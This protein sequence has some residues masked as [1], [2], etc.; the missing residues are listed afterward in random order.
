M[1]N[2]IYLQLGYGG[3]V[4]SNDTAF[5]DRFM[6]WEGIYELIEK[7]GGF[8]N[9]ELMLLQNEW[10]ESSYINLKNTT[11]VNDIDKHVIKLTNDDI[12]DGYDF[13][14]GNDYHIIATL[15]P[16]S[17]HTKNTHQKIN[18]KSNPISN[19]ILNL[20]NEKPFV[21]LHIRKGSGV[22]GSKYSQTNTEGY[23]DFTWDY[24]DKLIQSIYEIFQKEKEDFYLYIGSDLP[25]SLLKDNLSHDFLTRLDFI[26]EK[27]EVELTNDIKEN[28]YLQSNITDWLS[29]Y[30]SDII[31]VNPFSS[32]SCKASDAGNN[33]KISLLDWSHEFEWKIKEYLYK[34]EKVI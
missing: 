10:Q 23:P 11:V 22:I 34:E 2:K 32:F 9:F 14:V 6:Q 21:S 26:D 12:D 27:F 4:H 5:G 29:F 13:E 18:I 20:K 7:G 30:H 16:S 1:K 25:V 33:Q 19:Q 3:G 17:F 15:I 24:Y 28:I 8:A 31:F